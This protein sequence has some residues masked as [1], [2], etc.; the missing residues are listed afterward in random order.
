MQGRECIKDVLE[1]LYGIASPIVIG[2]EVVTLSEEK[3]SVSDFPIE[4]RC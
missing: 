4:F 1:R 3:K 2:K